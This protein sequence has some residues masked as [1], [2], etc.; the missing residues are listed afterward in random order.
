VGR[1]ASRM[2]GVAALT[3]VAIL[4]AV[5]GHAVAQEK[6]VRIG[7]QTLG[8]YT[9]LKQQ[10]TL[11]QRLRPLGYSITWSQFPGGPQLLDGLKIGAVD[12]AHAGEA[13]PIF[14]QA[15]G[16][17]LL[18]IGHEPASPRTEAIIVPTDSP[19]KT[20]NDLKGKKVA[21]NRGS[22]VHYLLVRVLERA[23]L[24][25]T[26]VELVFLPPAAGREAFENR[27]IDA[28]V[29]WEPYRAAAEMSSGARTLVDGTGL[30]SN[31]E[32]FFAA[33]A[34]ADTRPQVVD[35]V[36]DATRELYAE[37]VKDLSGTAKI[38]SATAGFP[39]PVLET[40]LSRRSFGVQP[41]SDSVIAEQQKIADTFKSLGPIPAAINVS[42]AVRKPSS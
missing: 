13:P 4:F 17:P 36:L 20:I 33:R 14:A 16:A 25:Y 12:L 22:N 19:L 34:F 5:G 7:H 2:I 32:F 28:W 26:D 1:I 37:V 9:L 23:G 27:S 18:Y 21:L 15:A 42:D 11:E 40:A 29:I 35:I 3:S 41:M 10:G 31:H 30:V 39:V 8:A 6:I 24:K 38:F